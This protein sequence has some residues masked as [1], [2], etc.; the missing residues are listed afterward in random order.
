MGPMACLAV[1]SHTYCS[2]GLHVCQPH[3]EKNLHVKG[4]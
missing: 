3:L 2:L 4:K 1:S